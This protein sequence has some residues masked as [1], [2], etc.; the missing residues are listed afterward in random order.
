MSK[1]TIL[2]E[3]LK[4]IENNELVYD[5][6]FLNDFLDNQEYLAVLKNYQL[7][8][9]EDS[10][11]ELLKIVD[12]LRSHIASLPKIVPSKSEEES[13]EILLFAF[14]R[15]AILSLEDSG[16]LNISSKKPIDLSD[17]YI[18]LAFKKEVILSKASFKAIAKIS[19]D[20]K[21][22][23]YDFRI[24]KSN[25]GVVAEVLAKTL[26]YKQSYLKTILAHRLSG[27]YK[28]KVAMGLTW[29]ERGI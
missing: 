23:I 9:S 22:S 11:V 3:V 24:D 5:F 13:S 8:Y 17:Q 20:K 6:Q 19:E 16:L 21:F 12:E 1:K 27:T 26:K 2:E 28:A 18:N 7:I 10:E 4:S 15:K 29:N 25:I 14:S